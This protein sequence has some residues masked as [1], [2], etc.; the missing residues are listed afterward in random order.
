M[1]FDIVTLGLLHTGEKG[2]PLVYTS[3]LH[4][5]FPDCN[6]LSLRRDRWI[7]VS[8][9]LPEWGQTVIVAYDETHGDEGTVGCETHYA[10]GV[11]TDSDSMRGGQPTHWMPLPEPPCCQDGATPLGKTT[12]D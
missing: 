1:P 9:R 12:P 7:P 11:W 4:E 10:D 3:R 2:N 8:E 5:A 6:G